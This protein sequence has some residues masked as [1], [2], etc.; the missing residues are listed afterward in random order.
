[1]FDIDVYENIK[2]LVK[3]ELDSIDSLI[4]SIGS[5]SYDFDNALLSFFKAP[6]KQI[7]SVVSFLF[8]KALGCEINDKFIKLQ[9]SI[10]I[11]HN[12]TLIHDDVIDNSLLRRGIETFNSKFDNSLAVISGDYLLSVALKHLLSIDNCEILNI[13]S[14]V[15]QKMCV[16]EITQYFDKFKLP[17]IENYIE[18]SK[19]KTA[20]LFMASFESACILCDFEKTF[21]IEFAEN[22]G[23]AFQIRDDILNFSKIDNKPVSNDYSNGIYTA[24]IIFANG[25][26][27]NISVGIEKAK[28]LL[29]NYLCCCKQILDNVIYSENIYKNA[30]LEILELLKL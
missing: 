5:V 22:F 15:I 9:T 12:A 19:Y 13:F 4:S 28:Q 25:N 18:K 30:L 2:L 6:S 7:R 23:I 29:D 26:I 8:F 21:A 27:E 1:M 20:S 10:E 3:P 24:P 11:I 14:E 16:G 17:N